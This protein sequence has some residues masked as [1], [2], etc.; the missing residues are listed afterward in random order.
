[1]GYLGQVSNTIQIDHGMQHLDKVQLNKV[2][3]P[4]SLVLSY[5]FHFSKALTIY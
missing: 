3:I 1:M 5:K 4:M 2:S